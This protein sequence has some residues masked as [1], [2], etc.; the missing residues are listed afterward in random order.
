MQE[1][2]S[3]NKNK[4]KPFRTKKIYSAQPAVQTREVRNPELKFHLY[5]FSYSYTLSVTVLTLLVALTKM[6]YNCPR[7]QHINNTVCFWPREKFISS[8]EDTKYKSG[9]IK[10]NKPLC[11]QKPGQKPTVSRKDTKKKATNKTITH[12]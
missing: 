11:H 4:T 6:F 2:S 3:V 12:E 8:S 9:K 10:R 1:N 7:H 5:M